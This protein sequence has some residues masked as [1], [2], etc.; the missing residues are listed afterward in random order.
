VT[1]AYEVA[2]IICDARPLLKEI[3]ALD[4]V[5]PA[6]AQMLMMFEVSRTL[7]HAC[8]WLIE[9]YGEDIDIV[10]SVDRLRPGMAKIYSRSS[11]YVSKASQARISAAK[12]AWLDMGVPEKLA[13]KISL[14]LL[15]RAAV[16][17]VDLANHCNRGVI[18]SA[19]L[20]SAFN[21]ALGLQWLHNSAEDL[22]VSGRWQARARGN[23]REDFYRLRRQIGDNL[24]TKRGTRDSREIARR[25]LA[26]HEKEVQQFTG[27]ID[28]MKLREN[29]DFATLS[30]AAQ[31]LRDL[32]AS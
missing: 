14:L 10:K 20:Y 6:K 16:D 27:M 23:L 18:E 26:K 9:Q 3:E 17:I 30:V 21:D 32:I 19:R 5:I 12:Q 4:H 24:L 13:N 2:R 11:S 22:T 15:T 29:I 31:E 28:E 1:R 25:W 7:R 8:Y